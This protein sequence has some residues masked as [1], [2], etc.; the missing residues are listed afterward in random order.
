[1]PINTFA[2]Q[3]VCCNVWKNSHLNVDSQNKLPYMS[4]FIIEIGWPIC[5]YACFRFSK[6]ANWKVV[7]WNIDQIIYGSRIAVA[8]WDLDTHKLWLHIGSRRRRRRQ[9][10][11]FTMWERSKDKINDLLLFFKYFSPNFMHAIWKEH[12]KA[13]IWVLLVIQ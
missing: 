8:P 11:Y 4:I 13:S 7:H 1:M 10:V 3:F 2:C 9:Y 5:V 6:G 12:S